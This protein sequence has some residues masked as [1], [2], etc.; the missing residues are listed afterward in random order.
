MIIII[1]FFTIIINYI[2]NMLCVI[3]VYTYLTFK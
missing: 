1:I 3:Y 2:Y